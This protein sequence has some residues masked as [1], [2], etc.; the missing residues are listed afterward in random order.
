MTWR[1]APDTPPVQLG[2]RLCLHIK[3]TRPYGHAS[4]SLVLKNTLMSSRPHVCWP[5]AT[6]HALLPPF[7]DPLF[8]PS[9]DHCSRPTPNWTVSLGWPE[10]G[11]HPTARQPRALYGPYLDHPLVRVHERLRCAPSVPQPHTCSPCV[12]KSLV[13]ISSHFLR[14]VQDGLSERNYTSVALLTPS[15][16]CRQTCRLSQSATL[17]LTWRPIL[18][19]TA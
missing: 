2:H 5:R 14:P 13:A 6:L 3:G 8:P 4:R 15:A 9:G 12:L 10:H 1:G 19:T 16:S 18:L 17:T 11:R 7:P